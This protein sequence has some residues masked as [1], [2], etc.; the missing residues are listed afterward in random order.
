MM[1]SNDSP[2]SITKSKTWETQ[3]EVLS[4]QSSPCL[5]LLDALL[6]S[7]SHLRSP[8]MPGVHIHWYILPLLHF[9]YFSFY[10][11]IF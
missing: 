8:V 2:E 7:L 5:P 1:S 11:I 3:R 4:V 9:Y 6:S 10:Y